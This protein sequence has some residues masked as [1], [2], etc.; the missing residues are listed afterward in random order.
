MDLHQAQQEFEPDTVFLNTASLGLPPR[1][2]VRVLTEALREWQR[3]EADPAAYDADVDRARRSYAGLVGVPV[4]RVAIGHQVSPLVGLVAASVPDGAEIVVAE[5]DFT[6]VTYPFLAQASRGVEVR[7]AP[8]EGI[9]DALTE[10]T[11]LVAVSRVQSAD[12]RLLDA[13]ALTEAAGDT[14]TRT[15]VDL[16]QATGWLPVEADR[17]D[18]TVC[19]AYKWL[20]GP[21]GTAFLTVR[22]DRLGDVVPHTAGWYAAADIWASIYGHDMQLADDARRLDSSPAWLSWVGT[23]E[24]LDFVTEVGTATLHEHAVGQANHF[25][26]GVG[27]PA[28]DSAIV[29]LAADDEVPALLDQHR[30]RAAVRAGRLRLSF[31]VSTTDADVDTA[32][33]ALRGHVAGSAEGT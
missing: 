17:F 13:D 20:L 27:L 16:T 1:R 21:R 31:H 14:G 9:A 6:S 25:L 18:Y 33:A 8:L 32:V 22:P 11:H 12:G 19:G 24:S 15:L 2:T 5:G 30:I 4:D 28:G 3:G 7:A 10:R 29:S 26:E 23:A